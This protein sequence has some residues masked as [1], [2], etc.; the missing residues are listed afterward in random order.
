LKEMCMC[1]L[2]ITFNLVS[3]ESNSFPCGTVIHV[4]IC[5]F[6]VLSSL[7]CVSLALKPGSK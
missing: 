2:K 4:C 1:V 5:V 3:I 7:F 6:Y